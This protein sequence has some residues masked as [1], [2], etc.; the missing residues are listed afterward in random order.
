MKVC[1]K[2]NA[3]KDESLFHKR[4]ASIDG[5]ASCCKEC[6]KKYDEARLRDPKRMAARIEYQKTKG[7]DAH[8]KACGKWV[9]NNTIKRAAHILVANAIRRGELVSKPCEICGEE[10]S[11]GHHDNYAYPLDVRWL[12]DIHHKQWHKENGEGLNAR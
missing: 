8:S 11:N 1:G 6:Q 7:K 10:K 4:S 9:A 5:L 2:C 3:E 12:C